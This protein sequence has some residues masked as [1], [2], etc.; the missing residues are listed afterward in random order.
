[1]VELTVIFEYCHFF[2]VQSE[3]QSIFFFLVVVNFY[4]LVGFYCFV[5]GLHSKSQVSLSVI[6]SVTSV[7]LLFFNMQFI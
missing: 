7:L 4:L 6:F 3:D 2:G 5:I 1:M